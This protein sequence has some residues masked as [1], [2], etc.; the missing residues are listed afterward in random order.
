MPMI[1]KLV[2]LNGKVI[3]ASTMEVDFSLARK[4]GKIQIGKKALFYKD[5]LKTICVPFEKMDRTFIRVVGGAASMCCGSM[6][7]E[8]YRLVVVHEDEEIV[9]FIVGE[10]LANLEEALK[11]LGQVNENVEIGFLK[12]EE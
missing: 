5:G 9:D 11:Y 7:Y 3:N 1:Q 4:F 2:D 10:D 6:D 12:P 8:Y